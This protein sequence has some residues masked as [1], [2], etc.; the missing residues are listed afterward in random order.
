VQ[1]STGLR[2]LGVGL[3]AGFGAYAA[4]LVVRA[5]HGV[6]LIGYPNGRRNRPDGWSAQEGEGYWTP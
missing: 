2:R 4:T 6:Y 5:A 1:R 3:G